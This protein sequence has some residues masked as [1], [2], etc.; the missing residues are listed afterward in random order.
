LW[1]D[2]E[3]EKLQIEKWSLDKNGFLKWKINISLSFE[4][5]EEMKDFLSKLVDENS[6]YIFYIEEFKFPIWKM[7]NWKKTKIDISMYIYYKEKT[8]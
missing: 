7:W 8:I 4:T 3:I 2:F 1:E 5:E 6:K